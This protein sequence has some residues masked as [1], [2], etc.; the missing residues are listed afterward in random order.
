MKK[1][2][3]SK[4]GYSTGQYGC[5]NEYFNFVA[6]D[7]DKV[8]GFT[9]SGMYGVESRVSHKLIELGFESIYLP[10]NIYGK[11]PAKEAKRAYSEY[12]TIENIDEILKHGYIE[13][14]KEYRKKAGLDALKK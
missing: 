2:F 3:Y 10:L 12:M 9:V 4:A 5:S 13:L 7:G 14:N 8:I 6:I 1:H 11:L